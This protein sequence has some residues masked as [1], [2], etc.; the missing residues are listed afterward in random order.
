MIVDCFWPNPSVCSSVASQDRPP[1]HIDDMTH[2]HERTGEESK[3]T[4]D[5]TRHSR[6]DNT[7]ERMRSIELQRNA[8]STI[9]IVS[10]AVSTK[11]NRRTIINTNAT[12]EM[13]VQSDIPC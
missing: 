5:D 9:K 4:E 11:G 13:R 2:A 7:P 6:P 3:M 12:I 8:S 1:D 10:L